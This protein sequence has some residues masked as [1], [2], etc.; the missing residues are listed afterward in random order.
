MPSPS[1]RLPWFYNCHLDVVAKR[2]DLRRVGTAVIDVAP[3]R[4]WN[5]F[6]DGYRYPGRGRWVVGAVWRVGLF[7]GGPVDNVGIVTS[8]FASNLEHRDVK[9]LGE[10]LISPFLFI[11]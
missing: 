11:F 7:A 3:R 1:V 2:R 8:D 9:N 5:L 4:L 6:D 10:T